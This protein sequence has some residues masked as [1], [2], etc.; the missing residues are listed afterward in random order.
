MRLLTRNLG[1]VQA[2][3]KRKT[4]RYY[5]RTIDL[6]FLFVLLLVCIFTFYVA[7]SFAILPI[8]WTF[9]AMLF[10][11]LIFGILF[12]LSLKKLPRCSILIKRFIIIVLTITIGTLGYFLNN[13]KSMVHRISRGN[14]FTTTPIHILVPKKSTIASI[15]D[16][17]GKTIGYQNG[18]DKSNAEYVEKELKA[19]LSSIESLHELDYTSLLSQMSLGYVHAV[20]ISD[21]FYEMSA[22]NIK[23]L[24]NTTKIIK[25]YK[26]QNPIEEK[27]TKDITKKAF[28]IYLS[29][30]DNMGSPDQQT[31]TD[32]NLILIVN[33]LANHID[34]VS[35][36]RDGYMPNSAL[37]NA[38]DKLT[39]TGLYGI[40]TSVKTIENFFGIPIDYYARISFNSLIE[41]VDTIG[42]ID[43]DVELDFC[44]QDEN[45][46]FKKEDLICL[47]KGK[48]E[49]SGKQALAYSRHRK[50]L[51]Y[52]NAGRE[53]AQ[54]RIIKA[55]ISK[56]IKPSAITY[57][58]ELMNIA[59][60]YV[61][62]DMPTSQITDF[63]SSELDSIKPWT[64]S[65]I[66]SDLGVYDTRYVASIAE[67]EGKKDV[68]LFN[69]NEVHAVLN[70]Y[71]G[72]SHSLNMQNFKFNLSTLYENTPPIP[73][74]FN[75]T[76]DTMADNPH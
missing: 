47:N 53:R 22:S 42:G 48:Q 72:A 71:D 21:S 29:G 63:I 66:T 4:K 3:P 70:A 27:K 17:T 44:E 23:D 36:P 13:S 35:L 19:K 51:G 12:S 73:N 39:H 52:D 69:K 41:I 10:V 16:L 76:W 59:P 58:N 46:S 18:V 74:E 26:K 25:T 65:S 75:I 7:F 43:V 8:R 1:G 45:R 31:H 9:I 62:T 61:I 33:P 28:T 37:H 6:I 32:T 2:M 20:A 54:Q 56:L 49:L 68:Y 38:N 34:M 64:I 5:T 15:D 67:N 60:N 14:T 57:V 50:T 55:I 30:L 40:D 24:K 11:I